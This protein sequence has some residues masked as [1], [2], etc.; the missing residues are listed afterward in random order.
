MQKSSITKISF[1]SEKE[2]KDG[3]YVSNANLFNS[4]DLSKFTFPLS[5][6]LNGPGEL[7]RFR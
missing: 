5:T 3:I 6:G 4:T 2:E 1:K 7:Q